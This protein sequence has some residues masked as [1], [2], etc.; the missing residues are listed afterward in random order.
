VFFNTKSLAELD[1]KEIMKKIHSSSLWE[2]W[3]DTS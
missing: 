1:F 3:M 2:K